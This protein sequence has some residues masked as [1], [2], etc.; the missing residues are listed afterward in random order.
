MI[1]TSS[2][3]ITK[4]SLR[5]RTCCFTG[6]RLIHSRDREQLV[7]RLEHTVL[8]LYQRGVRYYGAGGAIGFDTI[9]ADTILRLREKHQGLKLILVLPCETQTAKWKSASDIEHYN[10]I[11]G[12]AD[13]VKY[14]S[15]EY[16]S[17]CMHERN[18]HLVDNSSVCICYQTKPGGGTAYTVK[19]AQQKGLQVINVAE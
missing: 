18:R 11:M 12:Q 15:Q 4:P 7:S 14:I 2:T 16:T 10:Q 3:I 17:T 13:K 9:A 8:A 19:Y 1:E 5:E 6:H